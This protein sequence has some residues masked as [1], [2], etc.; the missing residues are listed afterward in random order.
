[1]KKI[2]KPSAPELKHFT[3]RKWFNFKWNKMEE[4]FIGK[5]KSPC[6]QFQR[7]Y[8]VQN[9]RLLQQS[10]IETLIQQQKNPPKP[11]WKQANTYIHSAPA[12]TQ[13]YHGT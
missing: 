7:E 11:S 4:L 13:E 1:M 3:Q 10:I 12:V 6:F 2:Q 9:N 8:R 5:L